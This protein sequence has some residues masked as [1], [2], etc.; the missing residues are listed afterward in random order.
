MNIL[1]SNPQKAQPCVNTRLLVYSVS[2]SVQRWKDF[3]YKERNNNKNLA[4]ANR[5]RV[6]CAHNMSRASP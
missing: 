2:K 5:P 6:N 1:C 4:I 3:A